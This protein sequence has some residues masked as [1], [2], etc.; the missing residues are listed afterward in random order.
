MSSTTRFPRMFAAL[1]G[2]AVLIASV[3]A[4]IS[5][6]QA[7]D[8]QTS[9]DETQ[10]EAI[11]QIVRGYLLEHPEIMLDV[12]A[13]LDEKRAADEALAARAAIEANKEALFNDDYSF[14]YGN[15]DGDITIVEF[16]DYKCP[17]CKKAVDDIMAAVEQDGN[18]R[19]VYKEFPILSEGSTIA[20]KAAMA[21]ISQ[22][23][24]MELHTALMASQGTLDEAR[25]LRIAEDAGLDVERLKQDMKDPGLDAAIDRNYELARILG[26]EGTPAFV[27][28]NQIVPGAVSTARL[29][30]VVEEER[31]SCVS[32]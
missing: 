28:G 8:A 24:Y 26:I 11:E 19:L 25:I 4:T 9:F 21:A 31:S 1:T 16:F 18:V 6:A 20:A 7:E 3:F 14:V 17:Y 30:E 27:I 10:T 2:G 15:P 13:K 12:F 22:N 32:C 5:L 23:K 29:L